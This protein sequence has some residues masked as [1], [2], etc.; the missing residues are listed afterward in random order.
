VDKAKDVPLKELQRTCEDDDPAFVLNWIHSNVVKAQVGPQLLQTVLKDVNYDKEQM[1]TFFAIVLVDATAAAY[2]RQICLNISG[3]HK[4]VK[5]YNE[6]ESM[7]AIREI[8]RNLT[9]LDAKVQYTEQG[10]AKDV[11]KLMADNKNKPNAELATDI[12]N[13]LQKKKSKLILGRLCHEQQ[14]LREAAATWQKI[15]K[16]VCSSNCQV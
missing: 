15:R 6:K 4:E 11:I 7:T 3:V 2:Y 10:L 8:L 5:T 14:A 12:A 9:D 1:S 13:L 16:Q